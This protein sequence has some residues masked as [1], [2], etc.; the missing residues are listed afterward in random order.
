MEPSG[1]LLGGGR[2]TG[3]MLLDQHGHMC[4]HTVRQWPSSGPAGNR[5]QD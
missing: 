3:G 5:K 1:G 2:L 4:V